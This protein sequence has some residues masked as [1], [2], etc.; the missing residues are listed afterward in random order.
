MY[1]NFFVFVNCVSNPNVYI[2]DGLNSLLH[3]Y[4]SVSY[5]KIK[6]LYLFTRSKGQDNNSHKIKLKTKS[7][8][9]FLGFSKYYNDEEIEITAKS[10]NTC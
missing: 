10:R 6:I 5:H 9:T 8:S 7:C 2:R 1:F 4:I 3:T